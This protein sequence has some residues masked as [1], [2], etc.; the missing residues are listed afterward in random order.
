MLE[1]DTE[2]RPN[3]LAPVS[4]LRPQE[5]G[6]VGITGGSNNKFGGEETGWPRH[7][8]QQLFCSHWLYWP[9]SPCICCGSG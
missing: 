9:T 1:G 8:S 4:R 6:L 5:K 2:R 7:Q 3:R